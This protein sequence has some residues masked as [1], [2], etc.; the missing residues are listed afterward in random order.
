MVSDF[1]RLCVDT[2]V[3]SSVDASAKKKKKKKRES[4][5]CDAL[6][7]FIQTSFRIVNKSLFENYKK[8]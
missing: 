4:N 1:R 5:R 6:D 7:T 2:G 8:C 3:S